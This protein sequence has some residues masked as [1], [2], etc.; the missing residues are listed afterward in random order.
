MTRQ[1]ISML[2]AA[3]LAWAAALSTKWMEND[4]RDNIG[5]F[6]P[7]GCPLIIRPSLYTIIQT[8]VFFC[9]AHRGAVAARQ[10]FWAA[11]G[12]RKDLIKSNLATRSAAWTETERKL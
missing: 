1:V 6:F 3:M 11:R 2:L 12:H 9:D 7:P 5:G 4:V 8:P 10:T